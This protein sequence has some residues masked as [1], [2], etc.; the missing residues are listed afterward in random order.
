[1]GLKSHKI[2]VRITESQLRFLNSFLIQEQRT[3]SS[4]LRDALNRYLIEESHRNEIKENY[5]N[6]DR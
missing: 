5:K 2:I 4:V 3:K 6:Q 1:M